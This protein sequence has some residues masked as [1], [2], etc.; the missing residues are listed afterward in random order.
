MKNIIYSVVSSDWTTCIWFTD[1][2][3][4]A[5]QLLYNHLTEY[6]DNTYI[7]MYEIPNEN[8]HWF[9]AWWEFQLQYC[10]Q[11]IFTDDYETMNIEYHCILEWSCTDDIKN[12]STIAQLCDLSFKK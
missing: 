9:I 8:I 1:D 7:D 4:T 6:S 3:H 5:Y 2:F 11:T 10:W 12:I